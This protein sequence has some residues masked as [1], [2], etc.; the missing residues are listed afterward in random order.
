M[1]MFF[2]HRSL[3]DQKSCDVKNLSARRYVS[4]ED[5]ATKGLV[6]FN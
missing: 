1:L 4:T 3:F 6:G 2:A 5:E